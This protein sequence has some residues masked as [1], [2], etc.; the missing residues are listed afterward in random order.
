MVVKARLEFRLISAKKTDYSHMLTLNLR[1][2]GSSVLKNMTIRLYSLDQGFSKKCSDAFLYALMPNAEKN[3]KFQAFISS[4]TQSYFSICGYA[5]GDAY[6]S[7]E[8]PVI[9]VKTKRSLEN[10]VLLT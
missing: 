8:S 1:N 9:T 4:L 3:V 2:V 10:N 6:F 5:N 7:V